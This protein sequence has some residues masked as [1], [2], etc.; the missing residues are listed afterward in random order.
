MYSAS[1][2]KKNYQKLIHDVEKTKYLLSLFGLSN[3]MYKLLVTLFVIKLYA[4]N[5][6][7]KYSAS[8]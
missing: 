4:R 3:I 7:F 2:N 6:I 5:S 8:L 1:E